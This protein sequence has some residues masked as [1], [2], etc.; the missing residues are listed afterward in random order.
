MSA[1]SLMPQSVRNLIDAVDASTRVVKKLA[2]STEKIVD[3]V[4]ELAT[5]LLSQQKQ[6][7]LTEISP[8]QPD[9]INTTGQQSSDQSEPET[10]S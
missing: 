2:E 10:A 6:R 8:S 4:D 5:I 7:L 1:N 9:Q 3:G